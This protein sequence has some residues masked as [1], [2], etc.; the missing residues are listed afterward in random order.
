M[1]AVSNDLGLRLAARLA[2]ITPRDLHELAC[3]VAGRRIAD[4]GDLTDDQAHR[5]SV[6]IARRHYAEEDAA[7]RRTSLA[8]LDDYRL[9]EW[10]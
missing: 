1:T 5:V 6:Q 10:D 2:G 3:A 9:E 8:R 4:L 7:V